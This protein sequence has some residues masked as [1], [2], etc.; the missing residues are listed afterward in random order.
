MQTTAIVGDLIWLSC[1]RKNAGPRKPIL[2]MTCIQVAKNC[3]S[4]KTS[5]PAEKFEKKNLK[6]STFYLY[7]G[8]N[9]RALL[10]MQAFFDY[11]MTERDG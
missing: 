1:D 4:R 7:A 10:R 5:L 9:T 8:M 6:H 2:C 11:V 3:S